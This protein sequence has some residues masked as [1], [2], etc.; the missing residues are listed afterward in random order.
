MLAVAK[1]HVFLVGMEGI[2]GEIVRDLV[3]HQPDM[4]IVAEVTATRE[5][6]PAAQLSGSG[7]VIACLAEGSEPLED[8]GELLERHPRIALVAVHGDGRQATLYR[9]RPE[10]IAIGE[11]SPATLIDAIRDPTRTAAGSL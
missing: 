5:L 7:V 10:R 11:L 4:D 9:V 3:A 6:L 8:W 1:I 2:L